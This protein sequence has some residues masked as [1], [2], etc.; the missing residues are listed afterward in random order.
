MH[1]GNNIALIQQLFQRYPDIHFMI[2]SGTVN[3][4]YQ[5]QNTQHY[6]AII[7]TESITTRAIKRIKTPFILSLDFDQHGQYMGDSELYENPHYW[8]DT[9]IIMTLNTVGTNEGI[10]LKLLQHYRQQYPTKTFIAA[11]GVRH[12]QDLETLEKIGIEQVLV[13]SAL[14]HN[15]SLI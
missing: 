2:D 1:T 13:A 12:Q 15:Q 4:A 8:P 7:G 10:A 14:H 9:L 3:T 11:G 5:S 6:T